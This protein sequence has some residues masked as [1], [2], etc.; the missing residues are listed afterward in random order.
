MFVPSC[1]PWYC[2]LVYSTAM[3]LGHGISTFIPTNPPSGAPDASAQVD[4]RGADELVGAEGGLAKLKGGESRVSI[5]AEGRGGDV[6]DSKT[7]VAVRM[8]NGD[9]TSSDR[10]CGVGSGQGPGVNGFVGGG[11]GGTGGSEGGGREIGGM[12]GEGGFGV[13]G[14]LAGGSECRKSHAAVN[15]E[16]IGGEREAGERGVGGL[17]EF[18]GSYYASLGLMSNEASVDEIRQ[19]YYALSKRYHPD[20]AG[21]T[22]HRTRLCK[23]QC[24][25]QVLSDPVKRT[26]YDIRNGFYKGHDR[27]AKLAEVERMQRDRAEHAAE[28]MKS[29]YDTVYPYEKGRGGVLIVKA[30]YGNL[31][32]KQEFIDCGYSGPISVDL[33]EGPWIDVTVPLQCQVNSSRLIIPGGA[34]TSKSDIDGF[35]APVSPTRSKMDYCL[36]VLYVFKSDLHETTVTDKQDLAIPLKSHRVNYEPTGPFSPSNLSSATQSRLLVDPVTPPIV[37]SSSDPRWSEGGSIE[38]ENDT[39]DRETVF[40][41]SLRRLKWICW[42]AAAGTVIGWIGVYLY[43]NYFDRHA[44]LEWSHVILKDTLPS[45]L[46]TFRDIVQK[47]I[48]EPLLSLHSYIIEIISRLFTSSSD[49][50]HR[51]IFAPIHGF[52]THLHP[53]PESPHSDRYMAPFSHHVIPVVERMQDILNTGY[54]HTRS[55]LD[56]ASDHVRTLAGSFPARW[57]MLSDDL[58]GVLMRHLPDTPS[59]QQ[60]S[61]WNARLG[62]PLIGS[63]WERAVQSMGSVK[64]GLYGPKRTA[65]GD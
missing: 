47:T 60:R 63:A 43:V 21:T 27:E 15:D 20:K 5:A 23:I 42:R 38:D 40:E 7:A 37:G 54:H 11:G 10:R 4:G 8:Q 44:L 55:T 30:W 14:R 49:V 64:Q 35:Y 53:L 57:G 65:G 2:L 41:A 59:Q 31:R 32:L 61:L 52:L 16:S 17:G 18:S 36:Y 51:H 62:V 33:V 39:A 29:Q 13:K 12:G 3:P 24:A 48:I 58:C 25:Y 19:A 1:D 45:G 22:E 50:I 6:G 26:I 9:V 34:F 28:L 56:I 46:A